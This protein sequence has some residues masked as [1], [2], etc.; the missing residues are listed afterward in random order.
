MAAAGTNAFRGA[1]GR[2]GFSVQ[3][4]NAVTD[5]NLGGITDIVQLARLGHEQIKRVCKVLRDE[6]IPVSVLAEQMF[7]VM[8]YWVKKRVRL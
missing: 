3:A 8:R 5:P 1:L 2:I 6:D 4:Q 7:D